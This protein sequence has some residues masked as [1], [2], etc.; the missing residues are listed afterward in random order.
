MHKW[1]MKLVDNDDQVCNIHFFSRMYCT[2]YSIKYNREIPEDV[3][4]HKMKSL[5]STY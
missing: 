4:C 3:S 2:H 5:N 1:Q